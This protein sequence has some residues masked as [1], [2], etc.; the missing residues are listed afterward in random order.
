MPLAD[1]CSQDT[2]SAN[3]EQL[4]AEGYARPVAVA[5]ALDHARK[6]GCDV[7]TLDDE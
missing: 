2:I 5:I 6:Q 4:V 1:G 3:I 7:D